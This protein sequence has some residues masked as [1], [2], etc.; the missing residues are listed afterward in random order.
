MKNKIFHTQDLCLHTNLVCAK[1]SAGME[2]SVKNKI[3]HTQDLCLRT[4]LIC[5]K[6]SAG[7]EIHMAKEEVFHFLSK[8]GKTKV[9]AVRWMPEDGSYHAILQITH[10]MIEF[11][12]R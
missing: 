8:D 6:N 7:M 2:I 1:N 4:N 10:G 11:I 5:A 12:E 9:H 3:F